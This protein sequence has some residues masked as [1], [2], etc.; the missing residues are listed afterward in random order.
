MNRS[1]IAR[2]DTYRIGPFF[3]TEEA[4]LAITIPSEREDVNVPYTFTPDELNDMGHKHRSTLDGIE[5]LK[6]QAKASAQ[7]FKLRI[8]NKENEERMLRMKLASGEE[9][10]PMRVAVH[11]DTP[12]GMKRYLHPE[13]GDFIREEQMQPADWQLPLIREEIAKNQKQA[14]EKGAE[15]IKSAKPAAAADT[16]TEGAS[17]PDG[18]SPVGAT[19]VGEK[20][21]AA[22]AKTTAP[23]F[24]LDLTKEDWD[25]KGLLSAFAKAAKLAGWTPIQ[26]STLKDI[27]RKAENVD[28]MIDTLRPYTIGS[29]HATT[30]AEAQAAETAPPNTMRTIVFG[31]ELPRIKF[32]FEEGWPAD[33][34]RAQFRQAARPLWPETI[35]DQVDEECQAIAA[36]MMSEPEAG[37]KVVQFLKPFTY[38]ERP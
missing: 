18:E 4:P 33:K 26:V 29:E 3:G 30:P 5:L 38:E 32:T 27:L 34:Y 10:R 35:L 2:K 17:R 36:S 6:D 8:Q 11:F 20:I 21:T 31:N 7:D 19:N 14:E 13:T 24:V 22:A 16:T 25:A 9:T 12:R 37:Q 1:P 23:Q 15:A 28:A